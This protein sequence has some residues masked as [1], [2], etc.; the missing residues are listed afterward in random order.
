VPSENVAA[1][2]NLSWRR[3]L[4]VWEQTLL[5]DLLLIIDNINLSAVV[6]RWGWIPDKGGEFTVKTTYELVVKM[7]IASGD[8]S[9]EEKFAFK[10]IWKSLAPSKAA[11]LAWRALLDRL[12]T[13]MNLFKR[14][15]IMQ[16][17][18]CLCV[19]CGEELETAAHLF[20]Y[21]PRITQLWDRIFAWLGLGFSLPHSLLSM[22]NFVASTS[23]GKQ[24][25][26]GLVMIW[27]SVLWSIWRHRNKVIFDTVAVDTSG[28][29]EEVK[30][31]SWKWWIGRSQAPSCLFY[32]WTM[33]P[34]ICLQR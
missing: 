20:L 19:F 29:V 34:V 32:E 28:L 25:R 17:E 30:I 24:L 15:I 4:F 12:P 23:G 27:N 11:A 5:D 16:V 8:L 6:D 9:P 14:R 21:C 10:V 3:R 33:E 18:E 1:S 2:W 13:R 31:N 26:H 22:L 7:F